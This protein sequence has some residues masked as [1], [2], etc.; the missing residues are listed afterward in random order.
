VRIGTRGSALALAQADIVSRAL[1]ATG[2]ATEA[3]AITTAGDRRAPDTAWGEGAFV[4]AIEE[5]LLDG[6][7]DV[8]VH[9]AKDVPT[10]EHPMLRIGAYLPRESAL[11]AL[12][13]RA[14]ALGTLDD[15]PPGTVVGTDSPRRRGFLLAR[16]PDLDVRPLHGNVDT[17]LR[18]LDDG[19]V[20]AL[21]LAVAGLAR[22]GRADRISQLLPAEVVPPA[23]G[24]GAIAAQTRADD[25]ATL[26]ALSAID[27][28]P[29]R[30]AVEAERAYLEATGGGCRAPVGALAT[31]VDDKLL[32]LAGFATLDGRVVGLEHGAA[33]VAEGAGLG[34]QLA[35]RIVERRSRLPGAP[36]VLVTRPETEA[37]RLAA[38]LAELGL[39]PVVVPAIE[40]DVIT[41]NQALDAAMGALAEYD[42]A[43]ATSPNAAR[44]V[45]AAAPDP[46]VLG[47]VRWAAVGRT[48][49]RALAAAGVTD[50]WL[51]ADSNAAA[52]AAG[53]PV[54]AGQRVLWLRGSLADEELVDTLVERGA[55]VTPLTVYRTVEAPEASR[56]KLGAA[57]AEAPIEAV[58]LA[59]PSAVRGVLEL[60]GPEANRI[61]GLPA[62]CVG[63]STARAAREAGFAV[64]AE[65]ESQ[66]VSA[67]AE[68][69]A[70][71]LMGVTT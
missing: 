61:L 26:A 48:T 6:R 38:R 53:L 41:P 30:T 5:A 32:M 58:V 42:W 27:D 34:R 44:A 17:R 21:V 59:S 16:R 2:A 10:D 11:D 67:L 15:L 71:Q 63:P 29:T 68:L 19:E 40:I 47:R 23:P 9:S 7:V 37:R 4:R 18:R 31:V 39:A 52:L 25:R 36:R 20:D 56:A 54:E 28:A 8:A 66:D 55:T 33:P 57:L 22:L 51:P 64:V 62:V 45:A 1:Q 49:A 60:A 14:G 3:V 13:L 50:A 35:E 46:A 69:T 24:Q 65:A 12:V 70:T 43:V